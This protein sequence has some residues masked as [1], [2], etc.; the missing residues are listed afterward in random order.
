MRA[1]NPSWSH[2]PLLLSQRAR[3]SHQ[4]RATRANCRCPYRH[5]QHRPSNTVASYASALALT[6]RQE[7]K[8]LWT[9]CSTSEVVPHN[10]SPS[11][12]RPAR[13]LCPFCS[14]L[15]FS[16]VVVV[17]LHVSHMFAYHH[18]RLS[19]IAMGGRVEK[20]RPLSTRSSFRTASLAVCKVDVT[21]EICCSA[22]SVALRAAPSPYKGCRSSPHRLPDVW[23]HI[24]AV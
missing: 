4:T 5:R 2:R 13:L 7:A 22:L 3:S 21:R 11:V 15:T 19:S 6:A 23:A 14:G 10:P 16:L 20:Q 12:S 9:R 18:F 24:S 17:D 1:L 8:E